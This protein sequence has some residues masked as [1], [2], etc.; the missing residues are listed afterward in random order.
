MRGPFYSF[1]GRDSTEF[2]QGLEFVMFFN[3]G[4]SQ[5]SFRKTG[6]IWVCVVAG[7]LFSACTSDPNS[8]QPPPEPEPQIQIVHVES[9]PREIPESLKPIFQLRCA[10]CHGADGRSGAGGDI[11]KARHRS[12]KNWQLFLRHPQQADPKNTMPAVTGLTDEEY[13][14]FADWLSKVSRTNPKFE[15]GKK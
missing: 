6:V 13:R 8:L 11:F 4:I 3:P 10:E 12:A 2:V 5:I 1:D 15:P 9:V 14:L 7:C